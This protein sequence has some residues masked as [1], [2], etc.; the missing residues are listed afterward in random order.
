MLVSESRATLIIEE[1]ADL[2]RFILLA[3]ANEDSSGSQLVESWERL[4]RL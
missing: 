4:A 1:D 3:I 2:E